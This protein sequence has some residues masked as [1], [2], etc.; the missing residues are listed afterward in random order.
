MLR[1]MIR[2]TSEAI[3]MITIMFLSMISVTGCG[4]QNE[5]QKL[6][7]KVLIIPKFEIG[8]MTGDFPGEAQ[9]FY[10]EYLAGGQ[11]FVIKGF[12]EKNRLYYKDG[13]A[14][15]LAGQGKVS[16]ALSTTAVLSDER[17]D[18]TEA[19]ILSEGCGGASEGIGILGDVFVISGS[20]DFDL[21]HRADHREMSDEIETTWFHDHHFDEYAYVN[22]DQDLTDK[23]YELIKDTKLKTTEKATAFLQKEYPDEAWA[24]REPKVM[25]GVSVTGDSFWKGKYEHRNAILIV[26]SY[27]FDEPYAITEM[28]DIAIGKVM[29]EY[30]LL[31][32]LI[33]L[34]VVVNLDVFAS[35]VTPEMLWG[36]LSKEYLASPESLESI[37]VFEVGMENCFKAGKII[38]DAILNGKLS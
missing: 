3:I 10:D 11:E 38:I 13:I 31:D 14:L 9:F 12:E 2:K 16:A 34:R 29:E 27:G 1:T 25:R 19:Y 8:G 6:P 33:D 30:G 35:G 20:A 7:V 22:L 24:N 21:G 23:V 5:D 17:F 36:P 26:E 32:R 37:D 18:F 28:E 4:K 15:W